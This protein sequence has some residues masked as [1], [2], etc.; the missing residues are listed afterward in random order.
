[1]AITIAAHLSDYYEGMTAGTA[2]RITMT[3]PGSGA[4]A[5]S[6]WCVHMPKARLVATPG[7]GDVNGNY[8]TTLSFEATEPSDTTGG[9]LVDLQKARFVVA[10]F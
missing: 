8:G 9:S 10:M 3:Q 2:Y 5:G 6:G 1:M 4:G 7:K